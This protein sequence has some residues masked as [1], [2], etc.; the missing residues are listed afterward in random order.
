MYD[1]AT[2]SKIVYTVREDKVSGYTV[3]TKVDADGLVT[4]TNTNK[5]CEESPDTGDDSPTMLWAFL[6]LRSGVAL[7]V[8]ILTGRKYRMPF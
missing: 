8:L 5:A 2:G 6:F 1:S 4:I 7:I 3:V